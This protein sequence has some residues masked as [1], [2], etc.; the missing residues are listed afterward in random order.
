M[1]AGPNGSGKST[2]NSKVPA[3]LLVN[4]INPH[5]IELSIRE[6]GGFEFTAF[7][8]DQYAI[9]A[10]AR[11]GSKA[12]SEACLMALS[13]VTFQACRAVQRERAPSPQGDVAAGR[14]YSSYFLHALARFFGAGTIMLTS[15]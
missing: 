1:F 4:Y 3:H 7:G 12:V 15:L 2:F 11:S 14:V 5:A 9:R 13:V 6:T 8:L 10:I